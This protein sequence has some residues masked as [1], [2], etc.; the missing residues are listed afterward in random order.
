MI[1]RAKALTFASVDE[2]YAKVFARAPSEVERR[3]GDGWM[4]RKPVYAH[5][6]LASNAFLF[7]D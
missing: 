2:A 4:E 6:L 1:E 5:A 3:L 7:V